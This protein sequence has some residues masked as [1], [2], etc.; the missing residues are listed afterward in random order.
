MKE[1]YS[2][3]EK[4]NKTI[5]KDHRDKKTTTGNMFPPNQKTQLNK[6]KQ[7]VIQKI[8]IIRKETSCREAQAG[9]ISST[10]KQKQKRKLSKNH[11]FRKRK[12]NMK[13]EK[14]LIKK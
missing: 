11:F 5:Q 2:T 7:T 10:Q 14:G 13:N 6:Q 12:N 9:N 4:S 8:K 3:K 1:E